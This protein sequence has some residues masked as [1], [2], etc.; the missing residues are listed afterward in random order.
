MRFKFKKG[1]IIMFANDPYY[2]KVNEKP[3]HNHYLILDN[4]KWYLYDV[5]CLD[6][7]EI[8]FLNKGDASNWA[9]KV[10]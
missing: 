1:D 6:D 9:V 7:G 5:L 3:P 10:A 4:K 8:T 2:V